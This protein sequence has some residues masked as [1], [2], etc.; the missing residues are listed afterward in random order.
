M[1]HKNEE[2]NTQNSNLAE[3]IYKKKL[4][5]EIKIVAFDTLLRTYKDSLTKLKLSGQEYRNT[6]FYLTSSAIV[7]IDNILTQVFG[8]GIEDE[9]NKQ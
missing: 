4:S 8:E 9:E 7:M 6:M 5:D 1:K 2:V 3:E